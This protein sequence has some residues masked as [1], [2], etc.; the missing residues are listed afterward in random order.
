MP[1]PS[2]RQAQSRHAAHLAL[3][4]LVALPLLTGCE[5]LAARSDNR[6]TVE[7]TGQNRF[8]PG[9][10]EVPRGATVVWIN[11]GRFEHTSTADPALARVPGHV[12][13]PAGADLWDSG[14]L[15]TGMTWEHTFEV[16][17]TYVYFCRPH[18]LDGMLGSITVLE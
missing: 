16:P 6:Y 4:T 14:E 17:G 5:I 10:I 7:M 12:I 13:L 8:M 9:T 2:I 3:I 11:R 18:E 1:H 15:D